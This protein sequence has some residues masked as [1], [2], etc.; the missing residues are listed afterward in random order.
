M[1]WQP[2]E[3]APEKQELLV[4]VTHSIG[5]DEWD[6]V[7]WVDCHKDFVWCWFPMM[8]WVPLPPTHWWDFGDGQAL[9]QPPENT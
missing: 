3:T 5:L 8:V 1:T 4:C 6:T 9:P 2:I 7:T